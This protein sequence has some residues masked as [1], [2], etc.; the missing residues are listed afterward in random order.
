MKCSKVV[1]T[2]K[3]RAGTRG[4]NRTVNPV[5]SY[6][7]YPDRTVLH[8]NTDLV[9]HHVK[10]AIGVHQRIPVKS[11]RNV[12]NGRTRHFWLAEVCP[13]SS[14]NKQLQTSECAGVMHRD[15]IDLSVGD[16]GTGRSAKATTESRSVGHDE[17]R[18]LLH[19]RRFIAVLD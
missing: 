18:I 8:A 5:C 7:T 2:I 19:R 11:Q 12:R 14:P 10:L 1:Q 13:E 4:G 17:R 16:R 9:W 3:M 6:H 15:H